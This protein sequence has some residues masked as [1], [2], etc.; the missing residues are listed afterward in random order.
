MLPNAPHPLHGLRVCGVRLAALRRV[1][2]PVQQVLA[3]LAKSHAPRQR[4][5]GNGIGISARV[6][7]RS[8]L[9]RF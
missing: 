5:F 6:A 7:R 1:A 4:D 9:R 8:G 3:C 2:Q